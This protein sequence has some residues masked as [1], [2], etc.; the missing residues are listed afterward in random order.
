MAIATNKIIDS[1]DI[2]SSFTPVGTIIMRISNNFI[3]GYF[4]CNGTAISR[5]IYADLFALI[6]T[7]YGD[8]DGITTFNIPNFT[9]CFLRGAGGNA[10]PVGTLQLNAAPNIT[11]NLQIPL[12][13]N[14]GTPQGLGNGAFADTSQA[15]GRTEHGGWNGRWYWM[16]FNASRSSAVYGRDSTQEVRPN[17]YAVFYYIKY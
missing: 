2:S 16:N 9:G 17:N 6:G 8:G 7:T 1:N 11:G 10:A 13:K 14:S 15:T 3:P 5:D 12:D 4:Q